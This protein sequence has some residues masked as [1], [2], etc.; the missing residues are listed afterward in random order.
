MSAPSRAVQS[1]ASQDLDETRARVA[2]L[3][4]EHGLALTRAGARL[5]Y[6]HQVVRGAA[7]CF[8]EIGYGA[9]V[10]VDAQALQRYFLV[11]LPLAGRDSLRLGHVAVDSTI[12]NATVHGPHEGFRMRWSADCRKLVLRLDRDALERCAADLVGAPL[13]SP[14]TFDAAMDVSDGA[15]LAWRTTAWQLM[16]DM[17][18]G[19]SAMAWPLARAQ[20]ETMLMTGLLLWQPN[21]AL[22]Q[23]RGA[24]G[25]AAPAPPRHV[26]LAEEYMLAHLDEPIALQDLAVHAG[27]SVRSLQHGFATH[28]DTTPLRHLRALR[29]ERVRQSLSDPGE[30]GRVTDIALRWGFCELGRFS[31]LYRRRFGERP[32]ETLRRRR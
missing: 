8:S 30:R 25:G 27:V 32:S 28:L 9:E 14:L 5:H 24:R 29:L 15:R 26:S 1:F 19:Q 23:L 17:R 7:C 6:R 21:S 13:A 31:V 16:H 3:F 2:G 12:A 18:Q 10:C 4:S 20:A 11:Q 22:R